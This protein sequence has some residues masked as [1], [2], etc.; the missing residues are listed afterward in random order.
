M[1]AAPFYAV[2]FLALYEMA[3]LFEEV[4]LFGAMLWHS[5]RIAI[6]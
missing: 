4:R 6:A 3:R 1:H 2:S 5:A